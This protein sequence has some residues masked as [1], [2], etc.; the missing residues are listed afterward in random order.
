M[1]LIIKKLKQVNNCFLNNDEKNFILSLDNKTK[2]INKK[3]K[4]Y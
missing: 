3:K 1:N 4:V 2:F